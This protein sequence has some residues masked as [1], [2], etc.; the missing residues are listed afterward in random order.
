LKRE[1]ELKKSCEVESS[2]KDD[3]K[4]SE[5]K[6]ESE[7][8]KREKKMREKRNNEF[9]CEGKCQECFLY[10]PAYQTLVQRCMF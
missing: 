3:E 9:L 5:R 10:K 4:E 8:K 6:K 1:N 7:K 2:K